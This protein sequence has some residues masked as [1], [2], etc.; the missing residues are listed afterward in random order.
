MS[1]CVWSGLSGLK[2]TYHVHSIGTSF[3]REPGNY[4][5]AKVVN[6]AW[7]P[8][9]IGQSDCLG[10]RCNPSHHK[11]DAAIRHGAT[12]IHAHLNTSGASARL[13]EETDLRSR[14]KTPCND[15]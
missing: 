9:Y 10:E 8:V 4:I 15:Q 14:F 13:N 6:G 12:H 2:Y 3:K 11:W 7:S 1:T 5:F